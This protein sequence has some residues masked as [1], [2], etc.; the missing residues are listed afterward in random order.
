MKVEVRKVRTDDRTGSV[1]ATIWIDGRRAG[2][3][4]SP[5]PGEANRYDFPDRGLLARFH[6][7][8]ESLTPLS[9]DPVAEL[10]ELPMNADL[11]VA[12]LLNRETVA[13]EFADLVVAGN[14]AFVLRDANPGE[15]L[16]LPRPYSPAVGTHLT[17]RYGGNLRT[18]VNENLEAALN[19]VAP[20]PKSSPVLAAAEPA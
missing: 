13:R 17:K 12:A 16:V 18:V 20:V 6:A 15:Y 3:V 8:C 14:T 1:S 10:P 19:V 4:T 2:R 11:F 9:P 7:H 5:S